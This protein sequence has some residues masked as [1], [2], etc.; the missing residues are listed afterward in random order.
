MQ[1]HMECI[2]GFTVYSCEP[3]LWTNAWTNVWPTRKGIPCKTTY[4]DVQGEHETT[5]TSVAWSCAC[6]IFLQAQLQLILNDHELK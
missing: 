1:E 5:M 6:L 4:V 2:S 3:F